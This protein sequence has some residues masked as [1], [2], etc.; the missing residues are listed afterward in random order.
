MPHRQRHG[1]LH[2]RAIPAVAMAGLLLIAAAAHAGDARPSG[3]PAGAT[4]GALLDAITGTA[5]RDFVEHQGDT[6]ELSDDPAGDPFIVARTP[7]G[8]VYTIGAYDCRPR[9][10]D[11]ACRVLNYR[12]RFDSGGMTELELLRKA[13]TWNADRLYG[14]AYRNADGHAEI[15]M[16][17]SFWRGASMES[18]ANAHEDWLSALT[19]FEAALTP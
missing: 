9:G 7:A 12:A 17:F 5:L 3:A 19:G 1:R 6:A 15:D 13:N 16:V 18:L 2:M 14:R 10:E 11:R 8:T 4:G